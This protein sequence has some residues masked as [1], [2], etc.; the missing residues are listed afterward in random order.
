MAAG[1]GG[2]TSVGEAYMFMAASLLQE[3]ILSSVKRWFRL[4]PTKRPRHDWT[5]LFMHIPKTAGSSVRHALGNCYPARQR[6][7]LYDPRTLEGAVW[8]D[9]F[10]GLSTER[11]SQ[12]R[13]VMG[14]FYY[15]LH[16]DVPGPAR[17]ATVVR[18]PVDRVV[19]HYHHY[20]T[21]ASDGGESRQSAERR[22]I[23]E[24]G[25]DLEAWVFD[26]GRREA[27]NQMVRQI[28]GRLA[29]PFGRCPDDMLTEALERIDEH[30]VEVLVVER[31]AES[32]HRLGIALHGSLPPLEK[33]NV[34]EGRSA[35]DDSD[36]RALDRIRE[37]NHLDD[38]L[39]QAMLARLD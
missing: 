10:G 14:H 9:R 28:T 34:N 32:W 25:L 20:R 6:L 11:R 33:L 12:L 23:V 7:Y 3:G 19:S 26:L 31:L 37:L 36:S 21:M 38:V 24:E 5:L 22:L 27:D 30:F 13:M 2:F 35:L 39:H 17:Y 15:G 4:R 18:D 16:I 1:F 8:P 29:E